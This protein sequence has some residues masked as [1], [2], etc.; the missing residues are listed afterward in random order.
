LILTVGIFVRPQ[1]L[2]IFKLAR[3][4][5]PKDAT[6]RAVRRLTA[7]KDVEKARAHERM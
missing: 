3:P 4:P 5:V 6:D 7:E 2:R 1:G